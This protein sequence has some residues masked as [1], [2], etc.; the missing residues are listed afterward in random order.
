VGR[1][2]QIAPRAVVGDDVSE[3]KKVA[4]ERLESLRV[5]FVTVFAKSIETCAIPPLLR[6]YLT[7]RR[8]RTVVMV[9]AFFNG[10]AGFMDG[11][12]VRYCRHLG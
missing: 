4:I 3:P 2:R 12:E 9:D 6:W 10:L 1:N 11:V 7:A 5:P 8:A